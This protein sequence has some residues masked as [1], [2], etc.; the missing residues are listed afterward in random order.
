[1]FRS[2]IVA[3]ALAVTSFA[4]AQ[5]PSAAVDLTP[6]PDAITI[7]PGLSWVPLRSGTG[8]NPAPDGYVKLRYT[9][10]KSDGKVMED[11]PAGQARV[12]A[13]ARMM[14]GW[15]AVVQTMAV[16][17]RRRAWISSEHGDGK[18]PAGTSLIIDT[19]LVEL[20]DGPKTPSD[21]TAPP[22]DAIVTKSGLA[23]KVLREPTGA[24]SP[25]RRSTVRVHYSGWTTEGRLFDSSV[26]RNTPAEFR[27]DQVIAGWT[28]GMQQMKEGEIR[29]FWIPAKL[30][31][32]DDP[33][34]PQGMLVFDIELIAVK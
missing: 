12:M 17:E 18:I 1:M 4:S 13:V 34:K 8:A 5:E 27:L 33:S 23:M 10:R 19:E 3:L 7:A 32:A 20:V 16:G 15:R 24:L 26:L 30:A 14:P 29:R 21:L 25:K 31:Y 2:A 28:E 9:I 11:V 22:A 6:S